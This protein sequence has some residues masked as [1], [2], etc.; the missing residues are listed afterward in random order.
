MKTSIFSAPHL[1][2][3]NERVCGDCA[4]LAGVSHLVSRSAH[5]DDESEKLPLVVFLHGASHQKHLM[6]LNAPPRLVA[7]NKLA[8]NP[9]FLLLSLLNNKNEPWSSERIIEQVW[10]CCKDYSVDRNRIY[11]TGVSAGGIAVWETICK[12]PDVFAAAVPVSAFNVS[13]AFQS[14]GALPVWAVH[15]GSDSVL[16]PQHFVRSMER[17]SGY[18]PNLRWTVL[19][20]REHDAWSWTYSNPDLWAWMFSQSR[21][22]SQNFTLNPPSS[23]VSQSRSLLNQSSLCID[24]SRSVMV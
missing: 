6:R 3:I 10:R 17:I 19:P 12:Y 11:I 23:I 15:G 4:D 9:P 5:S 2:A 7:E 18:L 1:P 24:R 21:I 13:P 22:L 14:T 20:D 8:F 16:L